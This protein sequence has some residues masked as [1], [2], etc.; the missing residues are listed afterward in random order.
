MA[1]NLVVVESPA[2]ARTIER[3]LG[4][5]FKVLASMGHVRDLPK[6]DLGVD[7]END[8]EPKYVTTRGRGN[9]LKDLRAAAKKAPSVYL[10]TDLD[11]EGEAIAWHLAEVLKLDPEQTYRVV[12]N[13]ITKG[14]IKD[15]FNQ[16]GRLDLQKV[17]AQQARRILDRLVGYKL[18][19]LLWRK[20]RRGLSAGRVQ[21]VAVRLI[22][23]REREIEA[24][25]PEEYWRIRATLRPEGVA[26][27]GQQFVADL[28]K[29]AGEKFRPARGE[30]AERVAEELRQAAYLIADRTVKQR[31]DK[32]PPPFITSEMQQTAST[33]LRFSGRRTM[34]IAQQLYEG[35]D[36]GQSGPVALITYMRTD[37][38]RVAQSALAACR[39]HIGQ[40]FGPDY[41]PEKPHYFS[42]K[43][44]AQEAHEAVRP[45][46]VSLTPDSVRK[47][48][49]EDQA[50]LYEL[51]WR[52]FVASQMKPAVWE[53]TNLAVTAGRGE[54][55]ATGRTL[56]YDGHTRL[57]G[58][59][60]GKDEQ[61]IPPVEAGQGLD[62][63]ELSPSQHFTQP[64]PRYSEATLIRKLESLGI[65]RPSTYASILSTIEDRGY[66]EQQDRRYHA[67]DVGK[68]VT[69]KLVE[70]FPNILNA[71]FTRHMEE[72]LDKIETGEMDHLAVLRE[73][74]KP[75]NSALEDAAE[76]M[77]RP[78]PK[79]TGRKCPE[80]GGKLQERMGRFGMFIGCENYPDCKYREKKA[81]T[82][83]K[84]EETDL[85]CPECGKP[86]VRVKSR[87]GAIYYACS[88]ANECGRMWPANK[89]TGEPYR[90]DDCS[91]CGKPM[92]L[93]LGRGEPFLG[94]SGYPECRNTISLT[95]RGKGGG[96]GGSR[97]RRGKALT[98]PTETPCEKCGKK[99]VVRMSRRGPFLACP[100]YPRC[101]NAKDATPEQIEAFN[102][103][104]AEADAK[105]EAD[106]KA[107]DEGDAEKAAS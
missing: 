20:I 46:D 98:L 61:M 4:K 30:D 59:R 62:L 51:I 67:T 104:Q 81:K 16:P 64:P 41:V 57:T 100:G 76:S 43:K 94:C 79:D 72:D 74:Y 54:L 6:S 73:F 83:P 69:D 25:K 58:V 101:R 40:A 39:E 36:L 48:L 88:E 102:A 93:R 70:H 15:A 27:E 65:G 63:A 66:V 34:S 7:V 13:E 78:E 52:R 75:F 37:S 53:V 80:C 92:V 10:A 22:V 28:I 105:A 24:F 50:K 11:R 49:T 8:F 97:G 38:H 84:G 21:S 103:L 89:E 82:P 33:Q 31:Q 60:L 5:D 77:T 95:P 85:P 23:E 71:D 86:L 14:A 45:T 91:E 42:S 68:V 17:N 2:K 35:V 90:P 29:F 3:Y 26:D 106:N 1:K 19:P 99:M 12:F 56:I 47:H 96:K 87:R 55:K 9:V 107:A 18:S 44:G 32:A